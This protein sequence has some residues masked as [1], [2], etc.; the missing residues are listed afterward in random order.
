MNSV[1]VPRL[2]ENISS[3]LFCGSFFPMVLLIVAVTA[4]CC[5]LHPQ[6]LHAALPPVLLDKLTV[7]DLSGHLEQLADPTGKLTLADI[8]Q[9]LNSTRF[10]QIP[11]NLNRGYTRDVLWL[12]FSIQRTASFSDD[13][14]LRL[15]PPYLDHVTVYLQSADNRALPS[16][17]SEILLGDHIPVSSRPVRHPEI[18]VPL[19][20]LPTERERMAYIRL[21]STST[22]NLEGSIHTSTDMINQN[23]HT[24]MTQAAYLGIAMMISLINLVFFVRIGEKLFLYFSLYIFSLFINQLGRGG[25]VSLVWPGQAHIIS[26]YLVGGGMGACTVF[27]SIFA[28]HLFDTARRPWVHRFFM[29]TTALGGVLFL[30]VPLDFYGSVA[31]LSVIALLAMIVL[32]TW[33]S[34]RY[35]IA[36][37]P[38]G[39]I[40]LSAF[41][42]S[43]LGY[44]V[45]LL[46]TLGLLPFAWWN[47]NAHL[48]A[49]LFNMVL[50]T[51]AIT[52]RLRTAEKKAI[53]AAREAEHK[54][55]GLAGEMTRELRKSKDKLEGAL[56]REQQ[57]LENKT[58]FL[59]ILSHE[60]RT[61][62]AIIQANLEL[63][64]LHQKESDG[65]NE[66]YLA[67][68]K[69]A[70]GRLVEIMEVSLQ[71]ERL[72]AFSTDNVSMRVEL[73]SLLDGIIDKAEVFWPERLFVFEPEVVNCTV[74]G[75]PKQIKTA[76]F[77][78]LDNACKYS[79][80]N[81]PITLTC[82][83]DGD[84]SVVSIGDHG[85]GLAVYEADIIFEKYRRGRSSQNTSGTGLGLWLVRQI[86][87]QPGGSVT[88]A[89]NKPKGTIATIRL[90]L[91]LPPL[92]EFVGCIHPT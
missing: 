60:Y 68:M 58:K 82:Y 45:L 85:E 92:S 88:L 22:L 62:L 81:T 61:P 42:L 30:S 73:I 48:I 36:G 69:H 8:L 41:G 10:T 24:V 5:P 25:L 74:T 16:S 86:V 52:E 19:Y 59:A 51:L 9:P 13:A 79:L 89:P 33:L 39:F 83:I 50:M 23:S 87:E 40:Y 11:G 17:Y 12:R 44:V 15:A 20:H 84:M 3:R 43:N 64:Q 67:K 63:V 55:V 65:R 66:P 38:G 4:L 1:V 27:F 53:T 80:P 34:L 21:Q 28:M 7:V 90:P 91:M 75:D 14:W 72:D 56:L 2:S 37:E 46:R 76:I 35:V 54:A 47:S 49:S 57:N 71:R 18:I 31:E 32:L 29:L 26:D 78:L 77:N 70:V 6:L